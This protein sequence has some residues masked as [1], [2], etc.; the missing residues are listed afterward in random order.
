MG[1]LPVSLLRSILPLPFF[2]FTE[3]EIKIQVKFEENIDQIKTISVILISLVF[4]Q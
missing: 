1:I 3:T 4:Y 2:N